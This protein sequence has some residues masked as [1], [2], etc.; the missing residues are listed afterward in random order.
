[1]GKRWGG[2]GLARGLLVVV[3]LS[4]SVERRDGWLQEHFLGHECHVGLSMRLSFAQ[5]A[6]G[7]S[8]FFRLCGSS[9]FSS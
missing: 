9:A 6:I 5:E 7:Q 8:C 4:G 3:R 1:M 2:G